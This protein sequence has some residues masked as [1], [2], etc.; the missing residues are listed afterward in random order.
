V[1]YTNNF[2]ILVK[3]DKVLAKMQQDDKEPK[4]G[5]IHSSFCLSS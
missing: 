4:R 5:S 3:I 1:R 2:V